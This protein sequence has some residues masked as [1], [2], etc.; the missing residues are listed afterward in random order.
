MNA[1]HRYLL[2]LE[3]DDLAEEHDRLVREANELLLYDGCKLEAVALVIL[4]HQV[5][6]RYEWVCQ[7]LWLAGPAE[8]EPY[9]QPRTA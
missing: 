9:A 5:K 1:I 2:E 7:R 3:A 6:S 8:P 4:A